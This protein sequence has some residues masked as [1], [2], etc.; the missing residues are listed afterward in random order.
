MNFDNP[1][2]QKSLRKTFG[3]RSLRPGQEQVIQ[4]VLDGRDTLAIMP[5]GGGKSLCY[6]LP[7]LSL[8]GTTLVVSPLISLMKDQVEKLEEIGVEVDQVN[9]SLGVEEEAE[10]LEN[11]SQARN[12]IVFVTPERLADPEFIARLQDLTI[13]LFVVDEAHCISQWGHDFRPAYL[14]L[15]NVIKALGNPT[16]LALTATATPEVMDDI[17]KQL[18]RKSVE[19][20]NTGLYRSNLH[21][22]VI[23]TTNAG[24]KIEELK[25]LIATT[26]GSGIIY[27]AT[28]RAVEELAASF[29]EMESHVTVYHGRLPKK[30]RSE[31]QESF[32]QGEKRIMIAT[33]AFGMGIDKPDIRFVVH[34]QIPGN[35]G[36]YYQECGRAG[37]DG[38]DAI[39][40]LLYDLNDKRIQQFFLARHYPTFEELK[41][42]YR[43]IT[44]LLEHH[45]VVELGQIH[46]RFNQFSE[47]KLQILLKLLQDRGIIVRNK[48]LG[49]RLG[50]KENPSEKILEVANTAHEKDIH[51][52][53]A[54]E[55]M[56][57]YAQ[58]GACRWK[59]LLEYFEEESAWEHCNHC[60]NCLEPPEQALE[61]GSADQPTSIDKEEAKASLQEELTVG[62]TVS[63]PK[64]G[65]GRVIACTA[66][67]VTI[68]FPAGEEGTYLRDHVEVAGNSSQ[69]N[70]SA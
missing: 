63:V 37:R 2:L 26:E 5:T 35:L 21:F 36:A 57:F 49:Y 23:H 65:Q 7:A 39:C 53:K 58:A 64:R 11:I 45:S 59:V 61:L 15:G 31:N 12:D 17:A 62:I 44:E 8:P 25:K 6:Q 68:A 19:L 20:V 18:G 33:N 14:E 70:I 47:R 40:T 16:I 67:M 32:M 34:F 3:L 22:R 1:K 69:E 24:E 10:A 48:T 51:H 46:E 52:R 4:N 41:G 43:G 56:I 60:D 55:D 29:R 30:T 9:S 27:A 54:L 50:K 42:V 38:K 13:S 66:D 28:V